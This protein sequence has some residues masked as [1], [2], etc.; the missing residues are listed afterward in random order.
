MA[1]VNSTSQKNMNTLQ[2]GSLNN[3]YRVTKGFPGNVP[4]NTYL[5][6]FAQHLVDGLTK[7]AEDEGVYLWRELREYLV[8]MTSS[9]SRDIPLVPVFPSGVF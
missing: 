7:I 8:Q 4:G 9:V 2:V 3:W 6:E 1:W 5:N